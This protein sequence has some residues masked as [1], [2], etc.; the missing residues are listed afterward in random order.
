MILRKGKTKHL[1]ENSI[2]SALL[3][4]ETYNSPRK[5]FKFESYIVLMINALTKLFHAYFNHSIGNKYYYK[6]VNGRFKIIDGE[7][8]SWELKTCIEK[9][10]D[11]TESVYQNILFFIKLRNKIVH[12]TV[13]QNEIGKIIFGECQSLLYNYEN[14]LIDFFGDEYAINESLAF[15]LQFSLLR[16][17]EQLLANK[18]LLSSE[19]IDIK[20][21]IEDYRKSLSDDIFNSQEFS[22]KLIQVPRV[23][24]T[25]RNDLAIEFVSWSQLSEEDR[26]K[27]DNLVTL[28]KPKVI[29]QDVSNLDKY[30]SGQ[31]V[32]MIID[33]VTIEFNFHDHKCLY[34][35]FSIHPYGYEKK[36]TEVYDTNTKYCLYD[37]PHHDYVF[38]IKWIDFIVSLIND[39]KMTKQEWCR[40]PLYF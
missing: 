36:E 34:F 40:H 27:Y 26:G 1:V 14:L 17:K 20:K 10:S 6:N 8:R 7:R 4:V 30:S 38:N 24:N 2:E 9:Y 3:A 19:M 23:T 22:I 37:E 25:N 21:F 13:D 28:I 29:K 33:K 32:R 31:A 18:R 11:I 16:T 12:S 35:I 5:E 15:S 39:R